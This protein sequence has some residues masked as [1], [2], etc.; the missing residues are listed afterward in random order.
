MHI[1]A[2]SN[3]LAHRRSIR[4]SI[5][6]AIGTVLMAAP[7]AAQAQTPPT[8]PN[9]VV[10]VIVTYAPGGGS[11]LLARLVGAKVADDTGQQWVVDNRPGGNATIGTQAI[12]RAAPDGY[13]IGVIDAALTINPGL[14]AKLPY[15]ATKDFSAVTMIASS[16]LLLLAHPSVPAKTAKALIALAKAQPGQLTFSS[17]GNGS[18]MH[19]SLELFRGAT[20]VNVIHVPYKGGGPSMA[21]IVSG[22]VAMSF[23]TP[24]AMATYIKAGRVRGLAITGAKRY[25]ALPDIPTLTESGINGVD[26]DPFWGVVTPAGTPQ[27]IVSRLH[28]LWVKPVNAADTRTRLV[29]MGFVPVANTPT[30]FATQIRNDVAKWIRVIKTAG[31]Q[32][33]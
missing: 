24:A 23:N 13:T 19:L 26:A 4:R 20:G 6:R 8:Y 14:Y 33:Q 28:E 1:C 12:A 17:S 16:P 5:A 9:R 31:I 7:C 32:P 25:A 15:D 27:P 21:A 3:Q 11:D 22:E 18:A 30:E 10:R 29:E 2:Q